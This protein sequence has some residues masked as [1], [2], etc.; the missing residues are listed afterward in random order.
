M[1]TMIDDGIT[2]GVYAPA[3]DNKLTDLKTFRDFL[4]FKDHPKYEKMLPTS[5]QH[6]RLYGAAKTHKFASPDIITTEILKF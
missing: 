2:Y 5:N 1:Q 3:T 6:A 4:Y